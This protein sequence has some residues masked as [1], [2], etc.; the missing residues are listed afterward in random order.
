[1]HL[2]EPQ[3]ASLAFRRASRKSNNT[4]RRP[5]LGRQVKL[6]RGGGLEGR[7]YAIDSQSG[8]FKSAFDARQGVL[9]ALGDA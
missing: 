5:R 2:L 8:E 1:M 6:R 7:L 9:V 4:S 3:L